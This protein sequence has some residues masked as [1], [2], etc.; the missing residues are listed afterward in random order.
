MKTYL[1][2]KGNPVLVTIDEVLPKLIL[3]QAIDRKTFRLLFLSQL[4]THE[5]IILMLLLDG[6]FVIN[7]LLLHDRN[8]GTEYVYCA[9]LCLDEEHGTPVGN[10][11]GVKLGGH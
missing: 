1:Y 3:T 6:C 8:N 7:S 9:K 10:A 11:L 5:D 2:A 4:L